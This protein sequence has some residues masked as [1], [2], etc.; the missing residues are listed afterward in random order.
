[1]TVLIFLGGIMVIFLYITRLSNND[2]INHLR[3]NSI[4]YII[5]VLIILTGL[6]TEDPK[7]LID[8]SLNSLIVFTNLYK[9]ENQGLILLIAIFLLLRLFRVVKFVESFKGA[10]TKFC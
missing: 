6:T 10:L 4:S 1:M 9:R 8:K 5:I 2:K 7:F 3:F